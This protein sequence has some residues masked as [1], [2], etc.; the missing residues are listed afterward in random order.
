M[1]MIDG[2]LATTHSSSA[3][4]SARQTRGKK[5]KRFLGVSISH[6]RFAFRKHGTH[7]LDELRRTGMMVVRATTHSSPVP[8]CCRCPCYRIRP[9]H[10]GIADNQESEV[11]KALAG[12]RQLLLVV[13]ANAVAYDGK[14]LVNFLTAGGLAV[15]GQIEVDDDFADKFLE[16]RI[17]L[18]SI[19]LYSQED[20]DTSDDWSKRHDA[21]RSSCHGQRY[22]WILIAQ[23]PMTL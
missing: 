4:T 11:Y 5:F 23:G 13:I 22:P 15:E 19:L 9:T 3:P 8:R 18:K 16:W 7:A 20:E 10:T 21:Q 17:E 6:G 2:G 1:M 14:K 12:A